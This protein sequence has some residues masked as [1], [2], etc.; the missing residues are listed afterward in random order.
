MLQRSSTK[1]YCCW[2]LRRANSTYAQ[3]KFD[4]KETANI[5]KLPAYTWRQQSNTGNTWITPAWSSSVC[6]EEGFIQVPGQWVPLAIHVALEIDSTGSSPAT[7]IRCF[8]VLI[9]SRSWYESDRWLINLL[10]PLIRTL[11]SWY[12]LFT[13]LRSLTKSVCTLFLYEYL[14]KLK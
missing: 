1:F 10:K 12:S 11:N 4:H 5:I 3:K 13:R 2:S 7:S 6:S 9:S 14:F 8:I